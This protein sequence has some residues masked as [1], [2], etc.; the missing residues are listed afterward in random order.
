VTRA[1]AGAEQG[2]EG[3]RA[4]E[5]VEWGFRWPDGEY[6]ADGIHAYPNP[7]TRLTEAARTTHRAMGARIFRRIRIVTPDVVTEWEEI[8]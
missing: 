6:I 2:G 8:R 3:L 4:T 1:D 5:H 7:D